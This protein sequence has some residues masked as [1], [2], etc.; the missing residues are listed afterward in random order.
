MRP[1]EAVAGVAQQSG[2]PA[3]FGRAV[4]LATVAACRSS[5]KKP[6][7]RHSPPLASLEIKLGITEYRLRWPMGDFVSVRNFSLLRRTI[8]ELFPQILYDSMGDLW[9][10]LKLGL[11]LSHLV[12]ER[13]KSSL[14]WEDRDGALSGR[15][16]GLESR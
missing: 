5:D 8:Y 4:A 10:W 3:A 9:R 7:E 11:R 15:H 14:A 12:F 2:S 13:H 6:S 1:S 16:T